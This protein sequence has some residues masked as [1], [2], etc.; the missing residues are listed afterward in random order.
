MV[1]TIHFCSISAALGKMKSDTKI[2]ILSEKYCVKYSNAKGAFSLNNCYEWI[3][4]VHMFKS[5]GKV[6][7]MLMTP[8][9]NLR[10]T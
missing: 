2:N 1:D 3:K 9:V 10:S 7:L 4:V 8:L 6:V 5:V